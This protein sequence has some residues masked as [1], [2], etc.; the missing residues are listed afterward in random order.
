MG[1]YFWVAVL[2]IAISVSLEAAENLSRFADYDAAMKSDV[3]H[4]M[5]VE[6]SKAND[7]VLESETS[8]SV[9]SGFVADAES[10]AALLEKLQPA[11][12]SC[13]LVLTQI[14]AVTQWAMALDPMERPQS[15][16]A[17]HKALINEP[18]RS[19]TPLS[20]AEKVRLQ[21]ESLIGDSS[22]AQAAQDGA[23]AR[24]S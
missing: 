13:P 2:A 3:A 14:A 5:A 4:P 12:K 9:L 10:A 7:D 16:F 20:V 18:P 6:W 21:L 17:F 15:V 19:Y 23:R 11:Y 8:E 1:K 22:K 24:A